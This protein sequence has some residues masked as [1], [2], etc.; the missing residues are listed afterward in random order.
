MNK[1]KNQLGMNPSTANYRLLRDLLFYKIKDQGCFRC[2]EKMTREDFTVEHVK[3]WLDSDDPIKNFFDIDNI[4]YSHHSCNARH[5]SRYGT[6]KTGEELSNHIR[7]YNR[8]YKL[9]LSEEE[10]KLRRRNQY[11]RTGK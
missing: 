5:H 8:N 9:K 3:P 1:K 2:G 7:D 10:R 6:G 11:L 4:S